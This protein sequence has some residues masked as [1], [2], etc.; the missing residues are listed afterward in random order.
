MRRYLLLSGF[1]LIKRRYKWFCLL[2]VVQLLF[3]YVAFDLL[4]ELFSEDFPQQRLINET[5]EELDSKRYLEDLLKGNADVAP[6]VEIPAPMPNI[7][8]GC[9][10][11]FKDA[12][13]NDNGWLNVNRWY[14]FSAFEDRRRN[15]LYPN[16]WTSIQILASTYHVVDET[17]ENWYCH[18]VTA[19]NHN[20]RVQAHFRLIWQRAWDPRL[21]FYNPY[22]I[23]C[24]L[25]NDFY[26]ETG[27]LLRASQTTN[28]QLG[29]ANQLRIGVCVKGLDFFED[30]RRE[31]AE[32]LLL[33][34]EL[35]AQSV[36]LYI[37][38]VPAKTRKLLDKM[39]ESFDLKLVSFSSFIPGNVTNEPESRHSYI[40]GN[41]PQKRRNE[42]IPY[43]DCF[44]RYSHTHDYVLLIDT[45]EVI[46]PLKHKNWSDL[47]AEFTTN[48]R[49]NATSL[50]ARN[51]FKFPDKNDGIGLLGRHRRASKI[52]ENGVSGKSFISTSTA[53]TVFNHFA[54][55]RLH[56]EVVRTAYFPVDLALKLHFK[57]ECPI[58]YKKECAK[59]K[60]STVEDHSLDKWQKKIVNRLEKYKDLFN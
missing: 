18:I 22:L 12:S 40:W 10:L 24:G 49:K 57:T 17:S 20:L 14:L 8:M 5:Q 30:N 32:W 29:Y 56:G 23:T 46:V 11:Q 26:I 47:I 3:F 35:G 50:S 53:A 21:T 1:S 6:V 16:L 33:Q 42:L 9:G 13:L 15:S 55:H 7:Y 52:Q 51:V 60:A 19:E 38:F 37:Y 59:L 36:T 44:Y 2:V 58:D 45:D 27:A 48:F 28:Y 34:Y 43:N 54:L 4:D 25:P 31:L 41:Y 39:A